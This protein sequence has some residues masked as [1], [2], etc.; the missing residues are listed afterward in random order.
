MAG[1]ANSE[2]ELRWREMLERQG[3]SGVSIREF[4][5][6]EGVSEP[7]FYAWRKKLGMRKDSSAWRQPARGGKDRSDNGSLFVPLQVLD[8]AASLEIIHPLGYRIQVSGDVNPVALRQ[9]IEVL[10]ERGGR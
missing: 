7:S 4:C 9:V 10:D 1:R 3:D 5:L 2:K 8:T 6:N